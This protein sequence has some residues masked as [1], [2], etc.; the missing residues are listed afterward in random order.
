MPYPIADY[1]LSKFILEVRRTD[2]SKYPVSSLRSIIGGIH[3]HYKEDRNRMDMDFLCATSPNFREFYTT[4]DGYLKELQGK[5][6]GTIKSADAV[7]AQDE[8]RLW[9]SGV[10]NTN[11]AQGLS[12]AVF[13]YAGKVFGIRGGSEHYT[14]TASQFNIVDSAMGEYLQYTERRVKKL[15]RG[16]STEGSPS[17]F[18]PALCHTGVGGPQRRG[19]F[20]KVSRDDTRRR[21]VL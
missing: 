7:T 8:E 16:C 11:T 20:Q 17:S 10:I 3:R 9:E 18:S 6:L 1:W 2:G 12:F 13:F 14:L 15:A 19:Y 4:Y 21:P 5:G